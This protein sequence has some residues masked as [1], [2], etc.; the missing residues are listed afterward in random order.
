[1][2]MVPEPQKGSQKGSRPRYRDRRTIAAAN[3]SRR[4]AV[5]PTAR[6]PRLCRPAPEVSSSR[7]AVSC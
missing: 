2:A 4:G 7:E 5:T 1:M 6:Y 3:V